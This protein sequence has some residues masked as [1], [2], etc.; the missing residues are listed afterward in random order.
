KL[1]LFS[2]AGNRWQ[3]ALQAKHH[4]WHYYS[5]YLSFTQLHHSASK[6]IKKRPFRPRLRRSATQ[7]Y[8]Q[9]WDEQRRIDRGQR[10]S[11]AKYA[12]CRGSDALQKRSHYT[13]CQQRWR[14]SDLWL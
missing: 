12:T 7:T 1:A 8:Y 9:T 3:Y 10:K 13:L 4:L 11:W 5:P 2:P 6:Y 14:Q